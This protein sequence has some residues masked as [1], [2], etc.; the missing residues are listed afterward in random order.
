MNKAVKQVT[1][2]KFIQSLGSS[3]ISLIKLALSSHAARSA[4]PTR[5][6]FK[7]WRW[8][9]NCRKRPLLVYSLLILEKCLRV[10]LALKADFFTFLFSFFLTGSRRLWHL[11]G[12]S[13][14]LSMCNECFK[15]LVF[16]LRLT[17]TS[18]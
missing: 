9:T 4:P 5:D 2:L 1:S 3:F 13:V 12:K 18:F 14:V 10:D 16:I 7:S 8:S 6:F 17:R 15:Y 11:S